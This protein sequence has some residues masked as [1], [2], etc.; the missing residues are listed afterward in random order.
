MGVRRK[1]GILIGRK[2]DGWRFFRVFVDEGVVIIKGYL[3]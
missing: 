3:F 1:F 2:F